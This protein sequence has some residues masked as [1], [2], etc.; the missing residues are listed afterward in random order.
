[1]VQSLTQPVTFEEFVA[2]YPNSGG[3]YELHD[4]IIVEMPK[5]IGKHSN[6]TGFLFVL[7]ISYSCR[8]FGTA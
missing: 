3:R 2:W 7:H 5:L 6:I 4:G 8:R 1:M